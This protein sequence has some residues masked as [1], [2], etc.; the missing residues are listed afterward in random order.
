MIHIQNCE[1]KVLNNLQVACTFLFSPEYAKDLNFIK[2]LELS[3]VKKAFRAKVKKYHPDLHQ[4][5]S[6]SMIRRRIERFNNIKQSYNLL[7]LNITEKAPGKI[8]A[9]GGAK[10]GIGKSMFAANLGVYLSNMGYE[11]AIVDLD[12]GGANLHLYLGETSIDKKVNDFLLGTASSI[13]DIMIKSKYGPH[14][15]GGDSS[16]LGIANIGFSQK[17]K[18][19]QAIKGIDKDRDDNP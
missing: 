5:D 17:L 19:F 2:N 1:G 18:L 10:G 14:F 8:I 15:I 9:I 6:H 16:Q 13:N 12:L 7:T 11:T 4:D 3:T